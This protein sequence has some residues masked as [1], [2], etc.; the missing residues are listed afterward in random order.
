MFRDLFEV[1][2]MVNGMV[3]NAVLTPITCDE[4]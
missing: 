1:L 2:A 3:V 4:V